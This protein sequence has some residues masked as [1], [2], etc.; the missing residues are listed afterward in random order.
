[1]GQKDV[2]Q[3]NGCHVFVGQYHGTIHLQASG[4]LIFLPNIFLP[5]ALSAF[6]TERVYPFHGEI[7]VLRCL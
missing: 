1:L 7:E 6:A 2:G 3:K 4:L 5:I